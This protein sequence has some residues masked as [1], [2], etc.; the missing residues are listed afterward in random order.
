[1]V[2]AFDGVNHEILLTKFNKQVQIQIL[3]NR[4]T[5]KNLNKILPFKY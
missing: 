2:K 1:M 4:Q 3:S 5:T